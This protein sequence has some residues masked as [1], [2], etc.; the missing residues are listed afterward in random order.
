[1][2]KPTKK[3]GAVAFE[4]YYASLYGYRWSKLRDALLGP[5]HQ[6]ARL[7]QFASQ[8][9]ERWHPLSEVPDRESRDKD[10]RPATLLCVMD[11]AS[12]WAAEI[13]LCRVPE[14]KS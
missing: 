1:M 4:E 6:V 5:K 2:P 10:S 14:G 3:R 8:L 9:D 13:L 11:P 7:N 12:C